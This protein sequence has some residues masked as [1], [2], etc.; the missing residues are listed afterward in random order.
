MDAKI[1]RS[2]KIKYQ[3]F[4]SIFPDKGLKGNE[5]SLNATDRGWKLVNGKHL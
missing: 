1:L 4:A 2:G 5:A 3:K